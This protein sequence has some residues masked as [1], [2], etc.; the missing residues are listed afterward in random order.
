MISVITT[1]IMAYLLGTGKIPVDIVTVVLLFVAFGADYFLTS[2][3]GTVEG[4]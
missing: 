4:K 3:F 1:G 2:R